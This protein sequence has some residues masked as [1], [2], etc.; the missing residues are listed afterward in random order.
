MLLDK[1]NT[2]SDIKHFSVEQLTQLA[3]EIRQFLIENLAVTGGHFGS[4][5]GVV[6]LTLALH[7]VFDTPKD[8]IIWDVGHQAYVHKILTGRKH[9]FPTLRKFKGMSGFPKRGESEHDAFDVGHSS[10]SISAALGYAV[11]RDMAKETHKVVAVI[12]DGA[13]TGG[14]AFEALNHAGSL[15]TDLLVVLNDNE[16]SIAPNVGAMKNYLTKLRVDPHYSSLKKDISSFLHKIGEFGDKTAR[17]LERFKDSV[18]YFLVP[19]MLF[20]ELGF[21]YLG[22][23]DGHDLPTLLHFM[24]QARKTKGPVLLHVVTQKGKG[25]AVAADAPDKM[26]SVSKGF[27]LPKKGEAPKVVKQ[28]PPQ[29]HNVFAD[30]MIRLA[31]QDEDIVAITPAMLPGSGLSKF[32]KR[33]PER[34]FDVGIAEQH[35]A[36]FAAGLAC[37]GKKPVLAIYSTFLQRAYDQTIHDIAIQNLPVVIAID[38]AGLVGQDGETHQGAFDV[39]F[40][41]CIPN[42][43]IM[44]PKDE[45][46]MQHM[47]YTAVEYEQGP[48]AVRYPRGEGQGVPMDDGFKLIPIGKS[49][50]VREG[51]DVAI[52]ALGPMVYV[53]MQ[54]ADMLAAEGIDARVVNMRFAKPL[55]EEML[56]E[57]AKQGIPIVT[58][59]EAAIAGGMGSAVLE[60]Y[61]QQRISGVELYPIGLPDRFIEHGAPQELLDAVGLNAEELAKEVKSLVPLKQKRA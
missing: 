31:E 26:H 16:M 7:Q 15:G 30:T 33:F 6:E 52:L 19:G 9:L 60:F 61:A 3:E 4:N 1:V 39:S 49:E 35:A 58:I 21:T 13:M 48:V 27:N 28:S 29:Y 46:E 10:T 56:L 32:Y 11:A 20:E 18:K 43:T 34:C 36:T 51:K 59:E 45:N 50:T 23:I 24:H 2:P 25:Y 38:R 57:L 5:L 17:V 47:L 22:P 41:R 44:A 42:L 8:K 40:L 53:A 54:A 55:D 12:G 37:G 14:M